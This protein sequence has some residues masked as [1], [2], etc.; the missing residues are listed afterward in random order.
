MFIS[1]YL[2]FIE[3]LKHIMVSIANAIK[4]NVN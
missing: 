3:R 2:I 1:E 4:H